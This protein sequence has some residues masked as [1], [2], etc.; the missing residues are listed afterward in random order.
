MNDSLPVIRVLRGHNRIGQECAEVRVP[1]A[2]AASMAK[3]MQ[4]VAGAV[5]ALARRDIAVSAPEF[6]YHT[7]GEAWVI[8]RIA[9]FSEESVQSDTREAIAAL[10]R[11]AECE[12]QARTLRHP[13]GLTL[14]RVT[15]DR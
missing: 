5:V 2:G 13:I 10:V 6:Q 12:A 4:I 3:A 8:G 15:V 14:Y 9:A 11:S 7:L 1:G